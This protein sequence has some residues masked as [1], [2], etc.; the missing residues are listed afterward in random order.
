MM[1]HKGFGSDKFRVWECEGELV[2]LGQKKPCILTDD[3]TS[4]TT[5]YCELPTNY[6][7]EPPC[8]CNI[9]ISQGISTLAATK[10]CMHGFSYVRLQ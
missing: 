10:V 9:V 5:Y 7:H 6:L 3:Q 4:S 8:I 2:A 1:V